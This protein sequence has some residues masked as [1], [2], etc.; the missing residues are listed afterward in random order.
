[1]IKAY[2]ITIEGQENSE[3]GTNRCIDS[4][5]ESGS[6][7][8]PIVFRAS[9]PSTL[10]KDI[11][12]P[13]YRH[14]LKEFNWTW[15]ENPLENCVDKETGL[16][17]Q[18]YVAANQ[19]KKR[20][21]SLSHIR[22]WL[23]CIEDNQPI[24]VLEHDAIFTRRFSYSDICDLEWGAVGL[25]DPRGATRKASVFYDEATK[26][27]TPGVYPVPTVN[28]FPDPDLPQGLAGHSSYVIRPFAAKEMINLIRKHG[29]WPN[30]ALMCKELCP[31]LRI[32][33]PFYTRIQGLRST[34]T[35]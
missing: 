12:D 15:P 28:T 7:L 35:T 18:A 27:K 4:I 16:Y 8:H 9:T 34:T 20:A 14:Y 29:V 31:W 5:K 30:D 11:S 19:D 3:K 21:C 24:V 10:K 25:N 23:R 2:I 6:R 1:M 33:Q 17:K 13:K 32:T 22:L 26:Y